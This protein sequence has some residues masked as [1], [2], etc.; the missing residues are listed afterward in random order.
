MAS[1]LNSANVEDSRPQ[2]WHPAVPGLSFVALIALLNGALNGFVAGIRTV[3]PASV[4]Y[5]YGVTLPLTPLGAGT[6]AVA[7]G[8]LGVC[9]L[10]MFVRSVGETQG[11]EFAPVS[12]EETLLRL[13]R[14]T[15]V[16]GLGL[17]ATVLGFALLVIPGFVVLVYLPYVFL[18]VVLEGRTITGAVGASHSRITERPATLTAASL[19]TVVALAGVGLLG[20]LTSV[21]PPT[22]EFVVGGVTSAL[23]VLAGTY[24][25]T[26]LYQRPSPKPKSKHGQL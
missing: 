17:L 13:G 4:Q 12:A 3:L 14:A 8:V 18:A 19:G 23:V 21:L 25:L 20:V 26:G 16:V 22:V 7:A 1:R 6:L 24:L 11:R 9:A 10:A 2:Y 5:D 15:A